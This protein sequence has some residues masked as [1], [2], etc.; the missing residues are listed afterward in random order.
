MS[1]ITIQRLNPMHAEA[2]RAMM[3]EAYEHHPD[4]FLS[5]TSERAALPLSWWQK[6]LDD[7]PEAKE[8]VLGALDEQGRLC[9]V[10]GLSV[11]VREK[12][13]HKATLFGM[14][15][16]PTCRGQGIGAQLVQA[17]LDEARNRQVHLV[18]L[19]VTRGNAA[20]E[21]LYA[22]Q[23]FQVFGVEPMALRL[24]EHFWD[25]VHMWRALQSPSNKEFWGEK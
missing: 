23:G 13:A 14:Y 16:P 5:S 21:R 25:K 17:V 20:A 22:A 1:Q 18:Q 2:Y 11:G 4:A 6:R 15:V 19:T 12:E 24:G 7:N 10:A 9:G 8:M 3:L